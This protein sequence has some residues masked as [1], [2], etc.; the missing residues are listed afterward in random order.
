MENA[1]NIQERNAG[2]LLRCF[3]SD[4]ENAEKIQSLITKKKPFPLKI[5]T[6]LTRRMSRFLDSEWYL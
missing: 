2:F 3:L 1:E 5:Y 6:N 4:A